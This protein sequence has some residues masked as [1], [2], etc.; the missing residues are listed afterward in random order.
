MTPRGKRTSKQNENA[1]TTVATQETQE[2]KVEYSADMIILAMKQT[3]QYL[4]HR[5]KFKS[6]LNDGNRPT[7]N[8]TCVFDIMDMDRVRSQKTVFCLAAEEIAMWFNSTLEVERELAGKRDTATFLLNK[9][10]KCVGVQPLCNGKSY[11]KKLYFNCLPGYER[12]KA[13][14]AFMGHD[15]DVG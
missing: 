5:V 7:G 8:C 3:E 15:W 1:A 13:A 14:G 6:C 4:L 11:T 2:N 9:Y 12:P 10:K